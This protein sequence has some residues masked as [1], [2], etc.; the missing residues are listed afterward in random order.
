MLVEFEHSSAL[1]GEA[2]QQ[3]I[4]ELSER[5]SVGMGKVAQALRV[6]ICGSAVSPAI[7][8]TLSLLGREKTLARIARAINYIRT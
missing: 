1:D 4:V 5:L 3:V 2:L 7:D 8:V 6:A